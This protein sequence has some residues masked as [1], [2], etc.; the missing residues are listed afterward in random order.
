[1]TP[2]RRLHGFIGHTIAMS[3]NDVGCLVCT[4]TLAFVYLSLCKN[5]HFYGKKSEYAGVA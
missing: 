5:P 3:E 1:M 2:T 4:I